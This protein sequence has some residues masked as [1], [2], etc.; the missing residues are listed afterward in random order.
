MDSPV[1][2]I[3]QPVDA[4]GYVFEESITLIDKE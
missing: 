2:G 1:V 3:Y 4:I